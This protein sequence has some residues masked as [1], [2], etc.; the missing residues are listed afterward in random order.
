MPPLSTDHFTPWAPLKPIADVEAAA[1]PQVPSFVSFWRRVRGDILSVRPEA[2]DRLDKHARSNSALTEEFHAVLSKPLSIPMLQ[3]LHVLATRDQ[4]AARVNL[5]DGTFRYVPFPYG[6][7]KDKPNHLSSGGQVVR[8]FCPPERVV[9]E[10][11]VMLAEHERLP[12]SMVDVRSAWLVHAFLLVHPFVDGNGRVSRLLANWNLI[13]AGLPPVW[14][15]SSERGSGWADA[16]DEAAKTSDLGPVARLLAGHQERLVSRLLLLAE[17][18]QPDT[19]VEQVLAHGATLELLRA[20]WTE[21]AA[22]MRARVPALAALAQTALQQLA[23]QLG[24]GLEV[25]LES[26]ATEKLWRQATESGVTADRHEPGSLITLSG[27]SPRTRLQIGLTA[28]GTSGSGAW[29]AFVRVRPRSTLPIQVPPL[30]LL[31]EEDDASRTARFAFWLDR[32]L[33]DAVGSWIRIA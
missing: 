18:P 5:H 4:T 25:V 30:T 20:R 1:Q 11:E 10:L 22:A 3:E 26:G 29:T 32:A 31:P 9:S 21:P 16:L 17:S 15:E 24:E 23:P 27:R 8:E 12:E 28:L 33:T 6:K 19:T 7:L 13:R 14:G 2:R